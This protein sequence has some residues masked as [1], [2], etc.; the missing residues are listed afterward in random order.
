MNKVFWTA[1]ISYRVFR[2]QNL[3]MK[4]FLEWMDKDS[5]LPRV[6]D[7]STLALFSFAY[8]V[9]HILDAS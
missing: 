5:E 3:N 7:N 9:I 8:W 2:F 1:R 4:S 6:D